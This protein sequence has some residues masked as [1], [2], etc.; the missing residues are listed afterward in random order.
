MILPSDA[1]GFEFGQGPPGLPGLPGAPGPRGLKGEKGERS[2]FTFEGKTIVGPAGP[3]DRPGMPGLDGLPG[4]PGVKAEQGES[5]HCTAEG[6]PG[7]KVRYNFM[8][9][10]IKVPTPL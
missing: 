5:G 8:N 2:V 1:A 10:A 6:R 4:L 9:V 7:V 3:P